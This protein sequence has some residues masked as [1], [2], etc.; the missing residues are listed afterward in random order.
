MDSYSKFINLFKSW[1][2]IQIYKIYLKV[3]FLFKIYIIY[4]KIPIYFKLRVQ[5]F[6]KKLIN[7][8]KL[9]FYNPCTFAITYTR[10]RKLELVFI[11][12]LLF[13]CVY[14]FIFLFWLFLQKK[15]KQKRLI[16]NELV[17]RD[18]PLSLGDWA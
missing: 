1:I 9:Q 18:Q 16:W 7:C 13:T 12:F 8:H 3:G 4:S 14:K 17:M 2:P 11:Y 6:P 15:R 10:I 5:R